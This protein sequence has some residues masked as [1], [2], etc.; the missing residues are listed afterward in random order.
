MKV[1]NNGS[2]WNCPSGK[3]GRINHPGESISQRK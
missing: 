2:G 3:K 1:K